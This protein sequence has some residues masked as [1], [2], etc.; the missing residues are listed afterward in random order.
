MADV[1]ALELQIT[2]NVKS[3]QKS[4]NSLISTLDK[5]KQATSGG[6]GLGAVA[7]EMGK[8]KDVN[9]KFSS[10]TASSAKSLVALGAK[11]TAAVYSLKKVTDVISSWVTESNNYVENMNLF[12]VAMGEYA[13]DAQKYAESVGEVLG[14]DPSTWMRNQGVFMTLGK[15]FGVASDRAAVMSQQLTQLGYDMSSFFNISVEDAMQRL[16]SGISGELEPLRRL[17]YDLSQAKLE[18]TALSLGIEKSVSSMTQAEKAEL[19]YYAIMNQVTDSHGDM[20]R[21]LEA[22]ANQ[23]RILKAQVE[24]AARALGNIFIP[25]LNAVLPYAIAAVKVIRLLANT[26]ANLVG[27]TLP[28]VD[29]SNINDASNSLEDAADSA[30]QLKRTLLGIDELNVL[31]DKTSDE[32]LTGGGFSFELPTYDF[33][34]EASNSKINEIVEKMKE[35]LGITE[36]IDSWAELFDTDLGTILTVVGE[37]GAGIGLWALS[38]GFVDGIGTLKT[39]L[40]S[41]T[42][43]IAIGVVLSIVGIE[44][45][46]D[47]WADA[48]DSGLGGFNVGE[49]IGGSLF[50]V[51]GAAVLGSIVVPWLEKVFMGKGISYA[52]AAIGTKM[53]MGSVAATG[54]ALAAA[55]AAIIAGLGAMFVGIYDAI[56]SELDWLNGALIAGGATAVGAGIGMLVGGPMGAL[57]GAGIGLAVGAVTDAGIWITQNVEDTISKITGIVGG[58]SLALGA[59]LALTGVNVPLGLGLI[60]AGA[61]SVGSVIAMN[62]TSLSD[63]VQGTIAVITACV[64]G[65]LLALGAVLAFTGVN[66]PL[67]IGLM[68]G[69]AFA[70]GGAVVPKWDT[71]SDGVK[72]TISIIMASLGGA[73]LVIGAILAFTGVG[74][75]LGIGLMV[76]GAASLGS[77]IALNWDTV[78]NSIKSVLASILAILSGASLVIG[79]LLCLTGAGI[80]LGLALIM[81]G[82]KG[83]V[84]ASKLDDNPITRFVKNMVNVLIGLINVV[85][86]AINGLFHIKFKG[87]KIGGVEIIPSIDTK[88]LNLSKIPMMADGGFVSDGQMF[89]AREAGPEMVGSIGNRSAVVN[90]EQIV[91]A[92][93]K[94]VYQAVVQAMGQSS[95]N[96]VVEAKVNDKVLFEVVLNRNRQ[97]TMRKGFNPLMGGV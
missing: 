43:S 40:S 79:V 86:D 47:G 13:S 30:K 77:S 38:K 45:M 34:G 25:A 17:G 20:A 76:A 85:I 91:S 16:Q 67:G 78:K 7:K 24:Q 48:I 92:V 29:Y 88:L 74:L 28:E 51:A 1:E 81:A 8:M 5:L 26:I 53:G 11:A 15:G 72:K 63:E 75:P 73:L 95:G 90:N 70:F 58:A 64:S 66:I 10:S 41:P 60:A 56:T 94:G 55:G 36:D 50:T 49:I 69:A 27:F 2:G 65:A 22:P 87:L 80:G 89:I 31:G 93:S 97:E 57:V 52:I 6:C 82:I 3:A 61:V 9:I 23:M 39:L 4:I 46:T 18:A 33:I 96:Q 44:L 71:L 19:R 54:V 59:I 12:T 37:I 68:A 35:W 84:T 14:I 32:D 83:S 62:L 42:Y 21:T